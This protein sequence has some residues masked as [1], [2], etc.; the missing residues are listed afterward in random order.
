VF[1]HILKVQ[2][3]IDTPFVSLRHESHAE[4]VF[5]NIKST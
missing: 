5:K 2:N 4:Y 3:T 1:L